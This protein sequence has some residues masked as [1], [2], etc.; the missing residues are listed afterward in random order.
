MDLSSAEQVHEGW[1]MRGRGS[2][3]WGVW[4]SVLPASSRKAPLRKGTYDVLEKHAGK[5]DGSGAGA[6]SYVC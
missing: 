5:E 1:G 6:D 2:M 4:L 3:G